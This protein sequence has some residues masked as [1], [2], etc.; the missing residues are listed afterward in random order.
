MAQ[1]GAAHILGDP[2]FDAMLFEARRLGGDAGD[3][4]VHA[5]GIAG[6]HHLQLGHYD[7]AV[8]EALQRVTDVLLAEPGSIPS[9]SAYFLVLCA[10]RSRT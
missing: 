2:A 6:D 5:S 4:V 3:A 8:A 1:L 7:A 9:D 10:A